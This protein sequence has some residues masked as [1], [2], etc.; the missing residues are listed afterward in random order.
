MIHCERVETE[1]KMYKQRNEQWN[2][3]SNEIRKRREKH[4]SGRGIVM[5]VPAA[6]TNKRV[7]RQKHRCRGCWHGV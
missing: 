6:A 7:H 4:S 5:V 3:T 1:N 2:T